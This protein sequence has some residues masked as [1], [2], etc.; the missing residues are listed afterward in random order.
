M[1]ASITS[2]PAFESRSWISFFRCSATAAVLPRSDIC[3]LVVRVVGVARREVA[4][5][6]FGLHLDVVLV[7]VDLEHRFGR[8]DDAPDDDRGDLDRVAL[9]VVDLELACSRSCAR[10]ARSASSCRTGSPSAGPASC[11][12]PDVVAEQLQHPAFVRIDDEEAGEQEAA[13]RR[14]RSASAR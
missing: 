11:A 2:T 14:A 5:R 3:V 10:A 8:V 1:R 12:V 13:S 7:V 9:V 6:R 4:Q